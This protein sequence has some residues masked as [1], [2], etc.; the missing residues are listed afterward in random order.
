MRHEGRRALITGAASGIG[1][2]TAQRFAGEGAALVLLD[3]DSAVE[4]VGRDLRAAGVDCVAH[5]VDIADAAAVESAVAMAA[6]ASGPLALLVNAA[7]IVDH[8]A[9]LT[10]M[11]PEAWMREIAV[12]LCGPFHLIRAVAPQMIAQGFGR[13]VNIS[14]MAAR[15]GLFRQSGYA[16]SKTGLLGLTRNATLE[17]ARSGITCNAVLPGLIATEKV[18]AMPLDIRSVSTAATPARRLGEPSE[19]A[20]LV[21]FLCTV[22]AGFINGAE[23]DISGG[24]HLHTLAL[25]SRRENAG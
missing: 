5:V 17:L 6:A 19:V 24:A 18:L 10:R 8:I 16:A 9:P 12:N 11:Q 21:S 14:S 25:G 15:G 13:I 22:E 20:A 2:A 1:R 3:R 23:I 7:G 4:D